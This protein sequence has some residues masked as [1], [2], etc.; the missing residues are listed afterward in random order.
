MSEPLEPCVTPFTVM[1][2]GLCILLPLAIPWFSAATCCA[3]HD[4][5][6]VPVHFSEAADADGPIANEN[7]PASNNM[8]I[9]LGFMG[10]NLLGCGSC[11]GTLRSP[12][13]LSAFLQFA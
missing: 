10:V 4:I 13:E 1:R 6:L 8:A 5:P 11:R 12:G 3:E 2:K 7:N 9:A